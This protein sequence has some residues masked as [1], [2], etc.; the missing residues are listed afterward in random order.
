MKTGRG[1]QFNAGLRV[2]PARV[3]LLLSP[4]QY[5]YIIWYGKLTP[6]WPV[7]S[8]ND[9]LFS[10]RLCSALLPLHV[11]HYPEDK[12]ASWLY[13]ICLR[14]SGTKGTAAQFKH[15]PCQQLPL[16]V[17]A[18][19]VK[20]SIAYSA[21]MC[22]YNADNGQNKTKQNNASC[23]AQPWEREEERR[24]EEEEFQLKWWIKAWWC[25]IDLPSSRM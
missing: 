16:T 4:V 3:M 20:A 22:R 6:T 12:A 1:N 8:V 23:P 15:D 7:T 25:L 5:I 14:G 2:S 9:T 24:G 11:P 18:P 21:P 13:S 10:Q 17:A 19:T